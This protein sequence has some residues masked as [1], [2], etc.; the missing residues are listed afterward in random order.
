MMDELEIELQDLAQAR[1][2]DDTTDADHSDQEPA[3]GEP[4]G[5]SPAS[6][7]I[8][9]IRREDHE[10]VLAERDAYK[11]HVDNLLGKLGSQTPQQTQDTKEALPDLRDVINRNFNEAT[12]EPLL[13]TLEQLERRIDAK[14]RSYTP[15]EEWDAA[16]PAL[17]QAILSVD[18]QRAQRSLL[19]EGYDQREIDRAQREMQRLIKDGARFSNYDN[20]YAAAMHYIERESRKKQAK[21]TVRGREEKE[22][23]A[24]RN[25]N[26]PPDTNANRRVL[27]TTKDEVLNDPLGVLDR[28]PRQVR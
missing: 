23:R 2:D 24:E 19:N 1:D 16:Q 22:A 11:Q 20:A 10:R 21:A 7:D 14:L 17:Q 27:K 15:R 3:G 8:E 13:N 5:D 25:D 9:H 6:G 18:E 4:D 28:I 26:S 12:R